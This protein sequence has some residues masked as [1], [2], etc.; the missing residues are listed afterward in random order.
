MSFLPRQFVKVNVFA[1]VHLSRVNLHD[2]RSCFFGGGGEL[3]LPVQSTRT[4]EGG[5]KDIDSVRRSNHLKNQKE[6]MFT[7]Q[8][9]PYTL[10]VL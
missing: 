8:G 7:L 4:Q 1:G 10:F 9:F 5:V 3:N 6:P 2:S